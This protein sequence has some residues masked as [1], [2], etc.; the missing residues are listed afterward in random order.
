MNGTRFKSLSAIAL[1]ITGTSWPG[2][3][4]FGVS[5]AAGAKR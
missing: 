5:K 1:S 3:R 4:F 2:P